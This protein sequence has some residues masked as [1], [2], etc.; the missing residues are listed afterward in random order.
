[1][2]APRL[3]NTDLAPIY[4]STFP[5]CKNEG[6]LRNR[7]RHRPVPYLNSI[8]EQDHRA[9]KRRVNAKQG[10]REFQAVRRT[11]QG[12]EAVNLIRKEQARWVA[13][14][15]LLRQIQFIDSLFESAA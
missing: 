7:C 2:S 14:D 3:I 11:I 8:L 12:Y 13:G 6:T 15:D 4:S 1:M 9:I 5:D 10:F